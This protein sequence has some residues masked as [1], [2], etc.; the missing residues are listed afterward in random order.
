MQKLLA[1]I[2]RCHRLA[3]A[4][5]ALGR[6]VQDAVSVWG[7]GEAGG[8]SAAALQTTGH[9]VGRAAQQEHCAG[10]PH[11]THRTQ[12]KESQLQ[13]QLMSVNLRLHLPFIFILYETVLSSHQC[14]LSL[15]ISQKVTFF[16][17]LL[18]LCRANHC[19]SHHIIPAHFLP[20]FPYF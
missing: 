11:L 5:E 2:M 3:V 8:G 6:P 18:H 7:R 10:L 12:D 17:P 1:F 19:F 20:L 9:G 4:A 14:L 15:C 13:V 16:F